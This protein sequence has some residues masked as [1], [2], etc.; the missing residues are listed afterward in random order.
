MTIYDPAPFSIGDEKNLKSW[1]LPT[2][3]EV[4]SSRLGSRPQPNRAV[5]EGGLLP[6]SHCLGSEQSI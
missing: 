5:S 4:F 3:P 1:T 2:L 6:P